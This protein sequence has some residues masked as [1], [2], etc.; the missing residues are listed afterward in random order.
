MKGRGIALLCF[1]PLRRACGPPHDIRLC[2][3][4]LLVRLGFLPCFVIRTA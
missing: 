4:L 3:G 2:S 1:T